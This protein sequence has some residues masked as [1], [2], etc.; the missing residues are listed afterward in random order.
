MCRFRRERRKRVARCLVTAA[1]AQ[2]VHLVL[3][4]GS[5]VYATGRGAA[6]TRVKLRAWRKRLLTK[7]KYAVTLTLF[8]VEGR[9]AT[10][11]R[12]VRLR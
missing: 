3:R 5:R 7:R 10:L 12:T 2:R 11:K 1:K 6:G 4:R 8:G 9:Q